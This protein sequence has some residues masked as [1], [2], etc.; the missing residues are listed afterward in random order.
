[1]NDQLM[2]DIG[3]NYE[4]IRTIINNKI[5]IFKIDL[6][7][8]VAKSLGLI[9]LALMLSGMFFILLAILIT[10]LIILLAEATGSV[11][12][13]LMISGIGLLIICTVIYLLRKPLLYRPVAKLFYSKI[14]DKI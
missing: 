14:A 5:E 12:I 1:M 3:E 10:A 2:T 6:A 13:G 8:N 9:I 4:Y 11:L 7:Q